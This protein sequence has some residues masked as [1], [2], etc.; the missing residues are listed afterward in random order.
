MTNADALIGNPNNSNDKYCFAKSDEIFLVF[1]PTG[2]TTDLD[3]TGARGTFSARW[4]NP[5]TGGNLQ[6]GS[7]AEIEGG[8]SVSLGTAPDSPEEDWLVIIQK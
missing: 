8:G 2:G 1:L 5:R 7:V 6:T 3:L 4:F